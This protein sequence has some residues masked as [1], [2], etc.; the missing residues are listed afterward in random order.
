M[1]KIKAQIGKTFVYFVEEDDQ[2]K[3]SF[4]SGRLEIH[5]FWR[6][7]ADKERIYDEL[8]IFIVKSLNKQEVAIT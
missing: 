1:K 4:K 6:W 7:L 3:N 5:E 8:A 2:D